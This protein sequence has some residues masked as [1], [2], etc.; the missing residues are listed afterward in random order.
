MQIENKDTYSVLISTLY[1]SR[2][3]CTDPLPDVH[4]TLIYIAECILFMS[5]LKHD[6]DVAAVGPISYRGMKGR[7]SDS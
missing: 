1:S 3:E 6:V 7:R 2:R 5:W 4:N